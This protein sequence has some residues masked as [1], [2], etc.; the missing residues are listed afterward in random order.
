MDVLPDLPATF[1][2]ARDGLHRLAC[3]VISPARKARTGRIGLRATGD[4]FATPPFDD[5][6]VIGVS[7]DR[8]LTAR[9]EA[10][11]TTLRDAAA[12]VGVELSADPG[13]GSDLPPFDADEDL[14]VDDA[15]SRSL[16]RWYAFGDAALDRL[17]VAVPPE[18]RVSEAQLWPEHFDL[19]VV[20]TLPGELDVN[21][22]FSPGDEFSDQPY[23]YVGPHVAPP[24]NDD[25]YWNAPFGAALPYGEL[26]AAPDP[27]ATVDRF[28]G[29]GLR[30]VEIGS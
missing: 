23:A 13:V 20:V 3:Y 26:A 22:G 7:G 19:A 6:S 21:V 25:P 17:R 18:G 11:I 2:A 30:R 27:H 10:P 9:G 15:A 5:G 12:L 8:L 16:G 28:I 4:G 24:A 1:A 14:E 29:E